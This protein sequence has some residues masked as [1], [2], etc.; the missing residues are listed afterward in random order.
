MAGKCETLLSW[1][2]AYY[3]AFDPRPARNSSRRTRLHPRVCRRANY[4]F[5]SV[6]NPTDWSQ[7]RHEIEA[8]VAICEGTAAHRDIQ[9]ERK[10]AEVVSQ[11]GALNICA[12]RGAERT[13]TADRKHRSAQRHGGTG[14]GLELKG[15]EPRSLLDLDAHH[16]KKSID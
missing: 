13:P 6:D 11:A 7:L 1:Q 4:P 10:H 16:L 2:A 5:I 3:R 12:R 9:H 8:D 15:L 14:R